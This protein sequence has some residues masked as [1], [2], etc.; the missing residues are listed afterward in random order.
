MNAIV[1]KQCLWPHCAI[2]RHWKWITS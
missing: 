2:K 1:A